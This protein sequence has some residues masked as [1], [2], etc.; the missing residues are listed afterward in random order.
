[1]ACNKETKLFPSLQT[2]PRNGLQE[3]TLFPVEL[4][5]W[6]PALQAI[7]SG[8]KSHQG[9]IVRDHP[10]KSLFNDEKLIEEVWEDQLDFVSVRSQTQRLHC[11]DG[12]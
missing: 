12:K 6:Y 9:L 5:I 7:M 10:E 11:T 2:S 1:M 4:G 3:T 8:R